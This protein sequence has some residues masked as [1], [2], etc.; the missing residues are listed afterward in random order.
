MEFTARFIFWNFIWKYYTRWATAKGKYPDYGD[1]E[2]ACKKLQ[3]TYI[4]NLEFI[5]YDPWL[6][7]KIVNFDKKFT[8]IT[9][10]YQDFP[11]ETL[12]YVEKAKQTQTFKSL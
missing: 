8:T 1:C 3:T 5:E 2:R 10:R 11:D 9:L 6:I 12:I 4:K 7:V